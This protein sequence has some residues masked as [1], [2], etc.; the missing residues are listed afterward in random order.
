MPEP[1]NNEEYILNSDWEELID[2]TDI[3]PLVTMTDENTPEY[4]VTINQPEGAT[5]TVALL[6]G[7]TKTETFTAKQ[8][9][10]YTVSISGDNASKLILNTNG[11]KV[12]GDMTI[13][14]RDYSQDDNPNYCSIIILQEHAEDQVIY[15]HVTNP[16]GTEDT[17]EYRNS[18][19]VQ[20]GSRCDFSLETNF[21]RKWDLGKLN[22]ESINPVTKN[23]N[24]VYATPPVIR[25]DFD[26][27]I[28]AVTIIQVPHMTI[29]VWTTAPGETTEVEHTETFN[30]KIGSTY[31]ITTTMESD[32][33]EGG[34]VL[35]P[36]TGTFN[37]DC[38]IT[39]VS[40]EL[41][42]F[43]VHIIQTAHQTITVNCNGANYTTDFVARKN[44]V[45]KA[46]ISSETNYKAGEITP[47]SSGTIVSD[48]T[49][50]ATPAKLAVL[51]LNMVPPWENTSDLYK[52][53]TAINSVVE[54]Y[55][56]YGNIWGSDEGGYIGNP[57]NAAWIQCTDSGKY[58][59]GSSHC[60]A[61]RRCYVKVTPGKTYNLHA[62]GRRYKGRA[63][64]F[65]L[66]QNDSIEQ[67]YANRCWI[68]DL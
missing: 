34:R 26:P 1:N 62:Y 46:T 15:C 39:G 58:W 53:F 44:S 20:P 54:L 59:F 60:A 2:Q 43:T 19:W 7:E 17:T 63:Y 64:G 51:T 56:P 23:V 48:I 38:T 11:G 4:T 9:T 36:T 6:S 32:W 24:Y 52:Q 33:Y 37:L 45:W 5:I 8:G 61:D 50:T 35:Y 41:V 13:E 21:V 28:C 29:H 40:P 22:V 18:I 3:T 25:D 16:D 49:I 65:V 14:A 57:G 27:T 31:R 68:E 42:M 12:L 47:Q 55:H 30:A 67:N 66:T 10:V